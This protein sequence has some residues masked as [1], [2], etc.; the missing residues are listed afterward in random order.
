MIVKADIV[1]KYSRGD[2]V[3]FKDNDNNF[4]TGIVSEAEVELVKENKYKILY[5]ILIPVYDDS[6]VTGISFRDETIYESGIL[7]ATSRD[8]LYQLYSQSNQLAYES[9]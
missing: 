9:K 2:M 6:K 4:Y 7:Y 5:H 8:I 3:L 1:T